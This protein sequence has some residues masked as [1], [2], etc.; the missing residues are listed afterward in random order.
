MKKTALTF[1]GFTFLFLITIQSQEYQ[2]V[3]KDGSFWDTSYISHGN[4]LTC[5]S[6]PI[7]YQVD[8]DVNINDKVYKKLKVYNI[9]G[10]TDENFPSES[11]LF[12]PFSIDPNN[13]S[14]SDDYIREDVEQKKLYLY[15]NRYEG[16]YKEYLISDFSLEIGG[17]IENYPL[18]ENDFENIELESITQSEF[19][20]DILAYNFSYGI[21]H[22]TGIGPAKGITNPDVGAS[23]DGGL[24][25]KCYGNA[26][27]QNNCQTIVL[28][29]EDFYHNNSIS[30]HPNPVI[31]NLHIGNLPVASTIKIYSSIGKKIKEIQTNSQNLTT[32][33]SELKKG[34]YYIKVF[35]KSEKNINPLK[36]LK[37]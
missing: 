24:D 20:N 21:S 14:F 31:N 26:E 11:C 19:S 1:I 3:I 7:R 13:F 12:A 23:L 30:F 37:L 25:L 29:S 10:T 36:I 16:V 9:E 35:S 5:E 34:I 15:T 6:N 8:S 2:P 22:L 33:L 27:S 18:G 28:N 4:N 32:N 17:V